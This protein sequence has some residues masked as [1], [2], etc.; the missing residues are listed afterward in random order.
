MPDRGRGHVLS[1]FFIN[2]HEKALLIDVTSS[3]LLICVAAPSNKIIL[4]NE[5]LI[6]S[7]G[8]SFQIH[9]INWDSN[10]SLECFPGVENLFM[11]ILFTAKHRV[12]KCMLIPTCSKLF[13][14]ASNSQL[15]QTWCA[16]EYRARGAEEG[17]LKT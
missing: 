11:N 6:S 16:E 10:S 2:A 17:A 3:G 15:S 5:T 12:R 7:V 9:I 8:S 14:G 13:S 4:R 1:S